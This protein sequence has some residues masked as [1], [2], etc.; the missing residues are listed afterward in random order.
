MSDKRICNDVDVAILGAGISGTILSLILAKN[1]VRTM[2]LD[3]GVHPRF[4][5]G[6]SPLRATT[7]WLRALA[8]R[9]SVPE[10]DVIANLSKINQQ[11][12]TKCGV[13]NG[14]GFVYH[15]EGLAKLDKCWVAN[16][17]AS[18]SENVQEAHFF[19]QDIDAY[20]Y[21]AALNSGVI[22]RCQTSIINLEFNRDCVLL[23]SDQGE[24][25]RASYVVDA[26]GY[27]SVIS[28]ALSL[29]EK[30]SSFR[31]R[32]RSIFT[33]M[34]GVRPFDECVSEPVPA[35]RWHSCTLH[36]MFD[37]GWIWVIPFGNHKHST[38]PLCSVGL[39]LDLS[40]FPKPEG[41]TPEEEWQEINSRFPAIAK[42]FEGAKPVRNWISTER[43]QY[44]NKKCVGDRYCLTSHAA[45]SVDALF[46]RGLLNTFQSLNITAALLL[47][48]VKDGD[49]SAQRFLRLEAQQQNLLEIQDDLVYGAY[50]ALRS[51]ELTQV[52]LGIFIFS[53]QL[54]IDHISQPF[55]RYLANEN[56]EELRFDDIN[57]SKCIAHYEEFRFLLKQCVSYMEAHERH[58]ASEE[59]T[60]R[61]LKSSLRDMRKIGF[62]Y[63]FMNSVISK[64]NFTK[65]AARYLK[66]EGLILDLM[67]R[68]S[69]EGKPL[70][71]FAVA[72]YIVRCLAKL[73]SQ[74]TNCDRV[75][76][77]EVMLNAKGKMTCN[78]PTSAE[79]TIELYLSAQQ[80]RQ[81]EETPAII[82]MVEEVYIRGYNN[83]TTNLD[84]MIQ[85]H[86]RKLQGLK[87][88]V[89]TKINDENEMVWVY[90]LKIDDI[91]QGIFIIFRNENQTF[92]TNISGQINF[93]RL[94]EL[95][96][97]VSSSN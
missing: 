77:Q 24:T 38:N 16:I 65:T 66:Y 17:A 63:D 74:M 94:N 26:S 4:A 55:S 85:D 52:W 76:Q 3:Q 12:S 92:L 45:G 14:F 28:R 22:G 50:M 79:P 72:P 86:D 37:G 84:E 57:P 21:N 59:E 33:H 68:F 13:K 53:E 95:L 29:R 69:F 36:H 71:R 90:L 10:L 7:L 1:G 5:L 78:L 67:D 23:E 58:L 49:F 34:V 9:F 81:G 18:Y 83:D 88:Q 82:V 20:L 73:M 31:T 32:S 44:S 80:I 35:I 19:R 41:K 11:V 97:S 89:T 27:K 61:E 39:N 96:E 30:T 40:R 25:F 15:T 60:L 62:N 48:A 43:L 51:S 56:L 75:E 8:T 91:V 54:S 6:E 46:S 64:V 93:G 2:I 70:R 42:Q 87:W 47:E